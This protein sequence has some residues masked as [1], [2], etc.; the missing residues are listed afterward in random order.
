MSSRTTSRGARPVFVGRDSLV[1]EILG[2]TPQEPGGFDLRGTLGAGKSTLLFH[3]RDDIQ[4]FQ[5]FLV[6]LEN[7]NPGHGGE[8]GERASVGAVQGSFQR[9]AA[10]LTTLVEQACPEDLAAFSSDVVDAYNSEVVGWR[11]YSIEEARKV[12]AR[13]LEP[14]DLADLWRAAATAVAESFVPR[15]NAVQEERLL[16]LDNVDEVAD[17]EIGA[18]LGQVLVRL[19]RTA[20]VLTSQ[21]EDAGAPCPLPMGDLMVVKEVPPFDQLDVDKYLELIE[22]TAVLDPERQTVYEISGGHPGTVTIVHNLLWQ[23]GV[24]PGANRE[25]AL[26]DL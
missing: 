18:W 15:W 9:F 26:R 22:P 3:L 21:V 16:L 17:Q 2:R 24:G 20:V 10:L 11:V 6:N 8:R 14:K 25:K 7:Y 4:V 13:R 19:E 23:R 1:A 12:L 5:R